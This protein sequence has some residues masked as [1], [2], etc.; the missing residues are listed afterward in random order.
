MSISAESPW[1]VAPRH[2]DFSEIHI[3]IDLELSIPTISRIA[4]AQ[5]FDRRQPMKATI[6]YDIKNASFSFELPQLPP[7]L[8]P[9]N[10]ARDGRS[11]DER[12]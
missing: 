6:P 2:P 11:I 12:R 10:H 5:E 9:I 4:A 7:N 3:K 1:F 8:N